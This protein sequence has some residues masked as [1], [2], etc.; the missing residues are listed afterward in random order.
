MRKRFIVAII[1]LAI[2]LIIVLAVS[3]FFSYI[4]GMLFGAN[5]EFRYHNGLLYISS[6]SG[7]AKGPLWAWIGIL[8]IPICSIISV[9]VI[10]LEFRYRGKKKKETVQ[11]YTESYTV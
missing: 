5:L 4:I 11:K 7:N 2:C 3:P 1:M 8:L 6:S 9:V 10:L